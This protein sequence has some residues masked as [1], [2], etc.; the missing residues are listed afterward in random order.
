MLVLP[1]GRVSESTKEDKTQL[2]EKRMEQTGDSQ[3]NVEIFKI[4]K[5]IKALEAAR[6]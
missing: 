2:K 5:L 4:K 6:G 1:C 3:Q